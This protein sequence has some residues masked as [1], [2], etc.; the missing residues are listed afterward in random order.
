[1]KEKWVVSVKTSLPNTCRSEEY[2]KTEICEFDSFEKARAS[3]RDIIRNFAFVQKNE[4]FD[5]NGNLTYM[6]KYIIKE[7]A[8]DSESILENVYSFLCDIFAGK[9]T[10]PDIEEAYDD[11]MIAYKSCG[12]TIEFFATSEGHWNGY[13]PRLKTNMFSMKEPKDYYLYI[14]DA[15]GQGE[16]HFSYASS[17]LYIDLKKE[18]I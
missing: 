1:M 5:G 2:L 12:G 10:L 14:D 8:E 13:N 17:E 4:M 6:Q 3:T 7:K 15:F 16:D 11:T 9:D 18:N